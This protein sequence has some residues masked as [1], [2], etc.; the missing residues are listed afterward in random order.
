MIELFLLHKTYQYFELILFYEIVIFAKELELPVSIKEKTVDTR[1][2]DTIVKLSTPVSILIV[3]V[4]MIYMYFT[5][6]N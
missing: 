4:V 2:A 6:N 3:F 1:F 5:Q